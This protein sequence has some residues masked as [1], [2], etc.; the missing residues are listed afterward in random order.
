MNWQAT[1]YHGLPLD[2]YTPGD[3]NGGYLAFLGRISPEKRVDRAIDIAER[4]NMK[5]KIA[6]NIDDA[7]REYVEKEIGLFWIT[8][9]W[10]L[11]ELSLPSNIVKKFVKTPMP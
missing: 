4:I 11:S 2:L 3:G 6:A 10:N 5:I 8:R 9:W 1:I 7:D